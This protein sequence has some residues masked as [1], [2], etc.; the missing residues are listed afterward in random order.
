[1]FRFT[2]F[3]FDQPQMGEQ[4]FQNHKIVIVIVMK[5]AKPVITIHDGINEDGLDLLKGC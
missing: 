3:S 1:M 5:K 2:A 4:E